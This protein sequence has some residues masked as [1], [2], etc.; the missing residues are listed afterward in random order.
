[1]SKFATN[2]HESLK[3]AHSITIATITRLVSLTNFTT[4]PRL[5]LQIRLRYNDESPTVISGC[6]NNGYLHGNHVVI[7][8]GESN[9][10]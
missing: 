5:A 1:M 10:Q 6:S 9:N 7:S 4:C 8:L 2:A 3:S